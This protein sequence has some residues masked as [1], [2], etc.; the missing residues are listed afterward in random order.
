[1]TLNV[2][3]SQRV[4]RPRDNG[5]L[6]VALPETGNSLTQDAEWCVVRVGNEWRRIRFHDYDELFGIP[7]LYEKVIYDILG[8]G[9]PET[10]CA[11]LDAA[12]KKEGESARTL[13]VLDFGAG[14][15][16]VGELLAQVQLLR[17]PGNLSYFGG[18]SRSGEI[19]LQT[20][21]PILSDIAGQEASPLTD[22]IQKLQRLPSRGRA[23]IQHTGRCW[24]LESAADCR[25]GW[26][27]DLDPALLEGLHFLQISDSSQDQR[28]CLTQRLN[29][30][31][32]LCQ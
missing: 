20:L 10:I 17:F 16:M 18:V 11:M 27:L 1:M 30:Y 19:V 26:I 24:G 15:G 14:N 23:K 32:L 12:L 31:I 21:E 13:R 4:S 25:R 7:G 29:Q 2:T 6:E 9:S 22:G 3:S 5:R 8:C 28:A